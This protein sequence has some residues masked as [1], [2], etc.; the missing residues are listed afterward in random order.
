MLRPWKLIFVSPI[1]GVLCLYSGFVYGLLYLLLTT[2]TSVF[3]ERYGWTIG[4][5]GLPYLGLGLGF[6]IGIVVIGGT[7][8]KIMQKQEQK[9]PER[10][11]PEIR[12][13]VCVWFSFLIP[14]SF[15]W[16][17]WS[18]D[19]GVM[20]VAP[21]TG[22]MVFGLGMIGI[23]LPVQTYMIDAFPDYAASSTAALASSRNVV[24]TFLPL[25]GPHLC[26]QIALLHRA[27]CLYLC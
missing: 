18:A 24:G 11:G 8:D 27:Y 23:F 7:S 14:V 4:E 16:Y 3:V 20:W 17:G 25:A 6:L 13:K 19:R 1:S 12:L 26:K 10:A 2:I 5:S 15:M 9:H 22:L 21:V